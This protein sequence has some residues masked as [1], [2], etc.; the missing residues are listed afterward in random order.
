MSKQL[1]TSVLAATVM[2]LSACASDPVYVNYSA[3]QSSA[4]D[5]YVIPDDAP[6]KVEISDPEVP[7]GNFRVSEPD[8]GAIETAELT[9]T[10][11]VDSLGNSSLQMNRR[12]GTAWE[13]LEAA[14]DELDIAISD[15]NRGEYQFQLRTGT[16]NTSLFSFFK[17]PEVLKIVLIPQGDN[18]LIAI[19]GENDEVPDSAEVDEIF[20][21]LYEHFQNAG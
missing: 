13:V 4:S 2:L 7:R 11:L 19:E 5:W 9:V 10:R 1:L 16:Q 18:T 8:A 3:A 17:S 20:G 6:A 12:P 15:R 14:L 21:R